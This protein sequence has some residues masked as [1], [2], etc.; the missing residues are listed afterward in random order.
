MSAANGPPRPL[1]EEGAE[2]ASRAHRAD[3]QPQALRFGRGGGVRHPGDRQRARPAPS[4]GSATA[5]ERFEVSGPASRTVARLEAYS[6]DLIFN[7]AEGRRGRFREAFYPALFDELGFPYTGS[8]AYALAVTLD[9]QLTKLILARARRPHA[10]A[11]SS[12]RS[13]SELKAEDAAL[14][15]HRQAELRGLAPRASPRTPSPRRVDE[16][17][18]K[19]AQALARYPAGVLVEEYIAGTRPDRAV[20]GRGATTTRRRAHPGGVRHRRGGHREAR[21]YRIYDYDAEDRSTTSAVSV[22]APADIPADD[23]GATCARWRR[24][25]SR[26]WTAGTSAAST[27]ALSDAGVP[28]FL[29][30]NALPSLEPGA[31][32]YAAAALEGL[33]LDG[34]DRRGHPERRASATRSRTRRGARASRRAR[35]ARCA[36][37][38]PTTS[39]ASS[40]RAD[41]A[42]RTARP[43]TTRPPRSRPSARRSPRWGHEVVDLEANAGAAHACWPARRWTSSS[44]SPRASRA[45]TARP[46]AR[47]AGA[48]RHPVHGQRSGHALASRWTRRWRRRS[49]ASAGIHTP[50]FQLM[51]TGQGAARQG[52]HRFPLIVK[53]VAEGS[54]KGVVQQER[55]QQRG[56]AARG[57]AGDGRQVPAAGADRGVHRR[58]RVHG[59]PARR[60]AAHACCRPMEIVFL[61]KEREDARSTA[62]STSSTG[63]IASATTCRR[64]SSRRSWRSCARRRAARSWR[65]GAATWRASTSA[66]TTRGAS[67]SSSATRCRASRRAGATWC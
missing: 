27:S 13:V 67:T 10:R 31:G 39:S 33:H 53:P 50:N 32:I 23:G 66:W 6:P 5:L 25:S 28:Y 18:A 30:I 14:P 1:A 4:S 15:G 51:T 34:G 43:S 37:A 45:A 59:G 40:P 9:K 60:A 12:S 11:G 36:W 47:A 16:L 65:W 22:R 61:D 8:D 17:R 19:V 54:S 20:P 64:S 42:R 3:V 48:A 56:G 21:R 46:G 62:S 52:V 29:E 49:S 57:G 41:G 7:T 55:L 44:T 2:G 35:A 24:R 26:C 58:A 38:S 63:T